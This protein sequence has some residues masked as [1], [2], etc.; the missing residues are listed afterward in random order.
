MNIVL[1]YG[2]LGFNTVPFTDIEYFNDIQKHLEDRFQARILIAEVTPVAGIEVRGNQLKRKILEALGQTGTPP[3]L[4]PDKKV[5]IIAHS[6]GGLDSRYILS[7]ANPDN[8]ADRVC[9]LTTIGTPH[10]G[11][12]LA[13]LCESF[14]DGE[15]DMP[16]LGAIEGI[17]RDIVS[18]FLWFDAVHDLT[19]ESMR[20]FNDIYIDNPQINYFCI[21]GEGRNGDE[22]SK[23]CKLLLP[24][25]RYIKRMTDE[26]NDGT[27]PISSAQPDGWEAISPPWPADHFDEVGHDLDGGVNSKPDHFDYLRKYEEIVERLR[28]LPG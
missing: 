11:S 25:H 9:S 7:P 13:D 15:S 3:V 23:T 24:A 17:I 4:D 1:A 18:K 22:S 26:E 21:A 8:I 14:V 19:T 5:H 2:I 6:M 28:E 16:L 27:M 12:P 20:K 10:Q